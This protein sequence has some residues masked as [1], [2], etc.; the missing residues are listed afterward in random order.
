M[1][2]LGYTA[3]LSG[4]TLALSSCYDGYD[5]DYYGYD[6]H[7][8]RCVGGWSIFTAGIVFQT[9]ATF[10][11]AISALRT[12]KWLGRRGIRVSRWRAAVAIPLSLIPYG[13]W[14]AAILAG[15]QARRNDRAMDAWRRGD[16]VAGRAWR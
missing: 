4:L 8:G 11:L 16:P 14:L 3:W 9:V 5:D 12:A 13:S 1:V 10:G 2:G 7:F 6:D 15:R